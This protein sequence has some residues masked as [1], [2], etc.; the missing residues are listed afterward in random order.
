[1]TK[2]DKKAVSTRRDY[3]GSNSLEL[4]D[5]NLTQFHRSGSV[6]VDDYISVKQIKQSAERS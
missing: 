3:F 4:N 2:L 6:G 5:S 1:V